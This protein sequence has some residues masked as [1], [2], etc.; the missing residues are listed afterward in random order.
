[1]KDLKSLKHFLIIRFIWIVVATAMAEAYIFDVLEKTLFRVLMNA[2][3]HTDS[4][5]DI[6]LA[7]MGMVAMSI[8][9]GAILGFIK[10]VIP[11]QMI[12]TLDLMLTAVNRF[13]SGIISLPDSGAAVSD[14][15]PFMRFLLALVILG[16]LILVLLPYAVA[17][18][19]FS[20]MV[21]R[22]FRA[23]E[24]REQQERDEYERKRN[25][26]LSDIAH[27]L[28]TPMTTVAG[29]A[30]A[31]EDG[32]V[33]EEKRAEIYSAIQTKSARMSDL[34][35]LLF[36]YVKLDSDG[37][38]LT[39]E[40]NDVCEMVRECVAFQYQDI[41]DAGM[42]ADV[43]IPDEPLMIN[44]DRLQLSRVI[45][46]LIT[47]AIRHNEAGARIG[48]LITHDSERIDIMICDSG[49]VIPAE[50]A[51]H[52]FEPFVTGDE[53]RNS[54]GGTGLGLS[55]AHKIVSM[56]GYRI[57]L[58]QR[59]DIARYKKAENYSKMFRITIPRS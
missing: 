24:D 35:N 11:E 26:M 12:R 53:S 6:G 8:L 21:I 28:R 15:S 42:E 27:D 4:I 22:E 58:I 23:I 7:R 14:L 10:A 19:I 25:L 59:P 18:V 30:K 48:V 37:F 17:A 20:G 55:I 33:P 54:R 32:M 41:E 50:T 52:I 2:F 34:I 46:N 51:E 40:D 45:T 5:A 43:D 47:N 29:Y 31:L 3:F 9:A 56:H 38:T 49:K 13:A 57:R 39:K 1:M 16:I 36:D 44:A